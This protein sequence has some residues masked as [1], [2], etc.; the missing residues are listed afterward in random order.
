MFEATHRGVRAVAGTPAGA[1]NRQPLYGGSRW[2][3]EW[4]A[5]HVVV[6][7]VVVIR[8]CRN[9]RGLNGIERTARSTSV[10][11]HTARVERSGVT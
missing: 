10:R 9:G 11:R 6:V 1:R 3:S 8:T 2:A 7:V 4:R 5:Q